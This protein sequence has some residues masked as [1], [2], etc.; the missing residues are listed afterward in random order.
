MFAALHLFAIGGIG[1][2]IAGHR[3]FAHKS[4][5]ATEKFKIFL[6]YCQTVAGQV[7][8]EMKLSPNLSSDIELLISKDSIYHSVTNHRVHHKFTD[9]DRDVSN[10]NRGFFF[11]Y[12]G[13]YFL[14]KHPDCQKEWDRVDVSD[15]VADKALM[16][17]FE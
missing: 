2:G 16:F 4:F 6:I 11:A 8:V 15:V 3:Y 14:P 9:T 1:T 10:I 12:V 13:N 5:K 7:S 17:Q